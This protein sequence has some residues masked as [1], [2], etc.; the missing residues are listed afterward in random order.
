MCEPLVLPIPGSFDAQA[1]YTRVIGAAGSGMPQ[2]VAELTPM[3]PEEPFILP[4]KM[5]GWYATWAPA[6]PC[7][8]TLRSHGFTSLH[9]RLC[10]SGRYVSSS[11]VFGV[12]DLPVLYRR[13]ELMAHK[14][15]LN[16]EPA[17]FFCLYERVRL[18]AFD[19]RQQRFRGTGYAQLPQV[20]L[21]DGVSNQ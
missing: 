12:G 15:Y 19:P 11:C 3:S 7:N 4:D 14:F 16:S 17:A 1:L 5:I 13:G 20:Q 10:D 9:M 21:H 8:G 18:R 6:G 2:T